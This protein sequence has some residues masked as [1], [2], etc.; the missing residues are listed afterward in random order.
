MIALEPHPG[1]TARDALDVLDADASGKQHA[2]LRNI[3]TMPGGNLMPARDVA[4]KYLRKYK[5]R[6]VDGICLT[7]GGNARTKTTLWVVRVV[8]RSAAEAALQ[9]AAGR[10]AARTGSAASWSPSR[11]SPALIT[12]SHGEGA[13]RRRSASQRRSGP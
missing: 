11:A 2:L 10:H 7:T 1:L 8:D 13:N 9:V 6:V 12:D 4:A 3:F 5:D